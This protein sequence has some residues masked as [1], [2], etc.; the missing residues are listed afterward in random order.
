MPTRMLTIEKLID[1][2]TIVLCVFVRSFQ[3]K[4]LS[5]TMAIAKATIHTGR[6]SKLRFALEVALDSLSDHCYG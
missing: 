5:T 6:E 3:I 2:S 1:T 4:S